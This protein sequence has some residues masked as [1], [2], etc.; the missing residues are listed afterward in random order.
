MKCI[1]HGSNSN[2]QIEDNVATLLND[3]LIRVEDEQLRDDLG[4]L[5]LEQPI[6]CGDGGDDNNINIEHFEC[7]SNVA[8][9]F[10]DRIIEH[11][12][13]FQQECQHKSNGQGWKGLRRPPLT[14]I[15]SINDPRWPADVP[16][17]TRIEWFTAD[18][19]EDEEA[20]AAA[21]EE[22]EEEEMN[23]VQ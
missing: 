7:D 18:T 16:L 20:E 15:R 19:D 12:M 5:Q 17:R 4:Y 9:V 3:L 13:S 23:G 10:F 8:N 6:K 1:C 11:P 2:E 14:S 21:D 22:E